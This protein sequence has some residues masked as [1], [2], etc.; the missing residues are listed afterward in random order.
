L[1]IVALVIAAASAVTVAPA[2]AGSGQ[3]NSGEKDGKGAP[4]PTA[5]LAWADCGEGFQCAT[6]TVPL[7]YELPKGPT[8]DLALIRRPA[9]DPTMRIGS[10]VTN[11]GGPGVSGIEDLRFS[12]A[13]YPA[14]LRA[15]FDLVSFDP[16]GVGASDPIICIDEASRMAERALDLSPDSPEERDALDQ[17][18][19]EFA[20]ACEAARGDDLA[21]FTTEAAAR[22]LDRIRDAVGDEKLT[23]FG[24]SYGTFLGATYAQLFPKKVRALVLDGGVDP[25]LT[26][27]ELALGQAQGYEAA[28]E[29]FLADCAARP[30]CAL[31][32]G[33]PT[34]GFDAL[35][36]RVEAEGIAASRFPD[37]RLGASDFHSAV[38]VVLSGGE[39]YWSYLGVWLTFAE[40]GDG[41]A[42]L[43]L[44]D[45]AAQVFR[46]DSFAA[47]A[48][49]GPF[50]FRRD[51]LDRLPELEVEA[52]QRAPHFG[53]ERVSG[54]PRTCARWPVRPAKSLRLRAKGAP[55]I[56]VIGVTNDPATP[57][58]WSEALADELDSG[59]LVSTPGFAHGA[60]LQTR[61][62]TGES[63][64]PEVPANQ[65]VDDIGIRYLVD[66]QAP[67]NP[68][69]C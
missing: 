23:Y 21:L 4:A 62:N 50:R 35:V 11:P 38:S 55:P 46:D 37:Q 51:V 28:L 44:A 56:L 59:V 40:N 3:G 69:A 60:F 15:R 32:A 7:D 26:G 68:T 58:A 43:A 48:C 36:A 20:D 47:I 29:G 42:L 30:N 27:E 45:G 61:F 31:G 18:A 57:F 25:T 64:P 54:L 39:P 65:C 6:L 52:R 13:R 24:V 9:E 49:L 34:A 10:L 17:R 22:D 1:A 19:R 8:I 14:E 67:K 12:A 16:R 53:L 2:G 66:L 41:S 33:D 63:G 5:P